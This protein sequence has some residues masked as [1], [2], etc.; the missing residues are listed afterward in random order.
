M[1]TCKDCGNT[2]NHAT[3]MYRHRSKGFCRGAPD[4]SIK[5][6]N[7][8]VE[9]M[10]VEELK[11]M[12]NTLQLTVNKLLGK[13]EAPTV[14]KTQSM[15]NDNSTSVSNTSITTNNNNNNSNNTTTNSNNTNNITININPFGKEN[16]EHITPEMFAQ[17]VRTRE[18]GIVE[19]VKLKH[20]SALQPGNHNIKAGSA[21]KFVLIHDDLGWVEKPL[22]KVLRHLF[23]KNTEMLESFFIDNEEIFQKQPQ[24]NALIEKFHDKARNNDIAVTKVVEPDLECLIRN[25]R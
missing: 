10:T 21:K 16:L 11:S 7:G 13:I 24:T 17:C 23:V 9:S 5:P 19:L 18:R 25:R 15:H 8:N 1:Y 3:N 22:K 4:T 6:I 14:S 20:F 2:F 12:V